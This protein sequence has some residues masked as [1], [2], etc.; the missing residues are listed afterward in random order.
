[1]DEPEM[2]TRQKWP[3]AQI[4]KITYPTGKIYI[5]SQPYLSY[6][7]FGS[8]NRDLINEDFLKLPEAVRKDY[9]CRKEILWDKENCPIKEMLAKEHELIRLHQS[10]NPE[11]GY[12][13]MPKFKAIDDS[14]IIVQE[15]KPSSVTGL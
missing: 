15:G 6:R 8:P 3:T 14:E 10:N 1:M 11:I 9:T 5:G 13:R 4:Y 12:N 2:T 7:Y